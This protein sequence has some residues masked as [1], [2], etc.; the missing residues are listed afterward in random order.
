MDRVLSILIIDELNEKELLFSS[1]DLMTIPNLNGDI[2][3][4]SSSLFNINKFEIS[5]KEKVNPVFIWD[6]LNIIQI[7]NFILIAC[8]NNVDIFQNTSL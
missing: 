5:H 7:I 1:Q 3:P 4:S 6:L 8:K 2:V